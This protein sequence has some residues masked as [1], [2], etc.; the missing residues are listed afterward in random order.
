MKFD[1]PLSAGVTKLL[2][3][4]VCGDQHALPLTHRPRPGI[5]LPLLLALGGSD[6]QA[7]N[8]NPSLMRYDRSELG[9]IDAGLYFVRSKV[10]YMYFLFFAY[11]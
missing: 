11:G 7:V 8:G 3:V 6:R 4:I 1:T 2:Q 10:L 5:L 9:H